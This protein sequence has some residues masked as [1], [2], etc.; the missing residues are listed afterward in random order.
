MITDKCT[1]DGVDAKLRRAAEAE[2]SRRLPDADETRPAK[3]AKQEEG[4]TLVQRFE[5]S[6]INDLADGVA[7]F[8]VSCSFRR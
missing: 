8:L 7:C 6:A 3:R 2:M 4:Y 5:Y 1:G